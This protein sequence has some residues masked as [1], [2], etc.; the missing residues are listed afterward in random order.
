MIE[1]FICE[2]EKDQRR[3]LTNFIHDYINAEGYDMRISLATANPQEILAYV[4]K[5]QPSGLYFIDIDLNT[6]I[7]GLQMASKIREKDKDSFIV[8]VTTHVELMQYT[9]K[10]K[11]E[12][13]DFINKGEFKEMRQQIVENIDYVHSYQKSVNEALTFKIEMN[14]R[15]ITEKLDN[16]MFFETSGNK[17][18]VIMHAQNRQ[19]EF[20][21]SLNEIEK[22]V[23]V[24]YRCHRSFLVNKNNIKEIDKTNRELI[25]KN[26]EVCLVSSRVINK[27]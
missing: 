23:D 16:I 21:G 22:Q 26:G 6:T 3:K 18:R 17:H 25:M 7:N 8:F 10:H 15:T 27:L 13:L 12:A 9:F 20:Y 2:D 1:I 4:E 5:H 19:I 14:N 11:L 24:F